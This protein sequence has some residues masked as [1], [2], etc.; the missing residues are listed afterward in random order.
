[1]TIPEAVGLVLQSATLGEAGDILV[2]EMGEP[3]KIIDV[4]RQLIELSGLRP[5]IDIEIRV[6][7][8]RPG[9]KL[10]EE[11]QCDGEQ[12]RPTAHP[13]IF[14]FISPAP[15]AASPAEL[16]A[17]VGALLRL[18]TAACKQGVRGLVPEYVPFV[19]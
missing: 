3:L 17:Q 11:L 10:V 14:R 12:F 13:R 15:S 16:A 5:D 9:E 1:M 18:E 6:V 8:L 2:L 19:E 7:G 4:A